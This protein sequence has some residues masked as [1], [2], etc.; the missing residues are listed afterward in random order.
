MKE[1]YQ[2]INIRDG[3]DNLHGTIIMIE[4]N[5]VIN[6]FGYESVIC[7]HYKDTELFFLPDKDELIN[8]ILA[9]AQKQG[10]WSPREDDYND[11]YVFLENNNRHVLVHRHVSFKNISHE[12]M[13]DSMI[14]HVSEIAHSGGNNFKCIKEEVWTIDTEKIATPHGVLFIEEVAF[15]EQGNLVGLQFT[16]NGTLKLDDFECSKGNE[17]NVDVATFALMR[18]PHNVWLWG[19]AFDRDGT[20]IVN[21]CGYDE[22]DGLLKFASFLEENY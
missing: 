12:E 3:E 17:G 11:E 19:Y 22:L 9:I 4:A 13:Y 10:I 21:F 1:K 16:V 20:P 7:G 6:N 18:Q 5:P 2:I 8:P 15:V 14:Y